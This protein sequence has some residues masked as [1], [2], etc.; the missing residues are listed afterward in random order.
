M[1]ILLFLFLLLLRLSQCII[2]PRSFFLFLPFPSPI[3]LHP[4]PRSLVPLVS[5]FFFSMFIFQFLFLLLFHLP[6]F[7]LSLF[8]ISIP[9]LSHLFLLIP[10]FSSHLLPFHLPPIAYHPIVITRQQQQPRSTSLTLQRC[11]HATRFLKI[12]K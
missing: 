5:S 11:E 6:S 9:S 1:L 10:I 12:V 7:V 2:S 4:L 8:L 3:S